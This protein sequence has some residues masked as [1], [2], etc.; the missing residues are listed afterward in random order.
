MWVNFVHATNAANHYATPPS[1]RT[2]S[3]ADLTMLT[4]EKWEFCSSKPSKS[5]LSSIAEPNVSVALRLTTSVFYPVLDPFNRCSIDVINDLYLIDYKEI[6]HRIHD[7][8]S[9]IDHRWMNLFDTCVIDDPRTRAKNR[10]WVET[11]LLLNFCS[12]L[13]RFL[14]R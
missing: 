8:T 3:V 2:P 5:A 1:P 11:D 12:K 10:S 7:K 13:M 9:A 14:I 6:S 4:R